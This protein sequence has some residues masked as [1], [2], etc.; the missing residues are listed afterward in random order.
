MTNGSLWFALSLAL[1]S[2][3]DNIAVGVVYGVAGVRVPFASNLAIAALTA[4]GTLASVGLGLPLAALLTPAAANRTSGG[5]L[6]ALGV[7]TLLREGR[8]PVRRHTGL[9]GRGGPLETL[10][11]I[12]Q[13]P[14][15][16]DRDASRHID[17]RE[18]LALSAALAMNNFANGL[19]AGIAG[20]DPWA[21]T[22]MVAFAS[23]ATLGAGL[24]AGGV[25][26]ARRFGAYAGYASG[27]LL[28]GLGVWRVWFWEA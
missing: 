19:A 17:L 7:W 6:I 23:I 8:K 10:S 14:L 4:S 2:N 11:M 26:R 3:V 20:I 27:V 16:A 12:L 1:S 5:L 24:A 28:T 18:V 22:A 13:D 15:Q 21:L 9:P 25:F